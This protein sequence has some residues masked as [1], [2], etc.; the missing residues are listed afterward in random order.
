LTPQSESD[1]DVQDPYVGRYA[2]GYVT[3]NGLRLH[4]TRWGD[5]DKPCVMLVHGLNSMLHAW[6][7]I[8]DALYHDF[9]VVSVDLRGHGDSEWAREGYAVQHLIAD[10]HELAGEL[11]LP[12]FDFVGHSLGCR[13]GIAYAGTYPDALRHLVLSD[14]GPEVSRDT[15]IQV[16]TRIARS[17]DVKGFRNEAEALAFFQDV[18]PEWRPE[19]HQLY[20][21]HQL[22]LNWAGKLV[23]KAD[24][25]VFWLTGSAGLREVPFLWENAARI[26]C[27]TLIMRGKRS[28][29]LSAETAAKMLTVI[30]RAQLVEF[31]TGHHIPREAP[32]EFIRVLRDFLA[33]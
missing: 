29:F 19:F 4:Y 25:D 22:R 21:Q 2:D 17:A 7:P 1:V 31:D 8:A 16:R 3:A 15:G 24:P 33:S 27:P 9:F 26:T 12:P 11:Q 18:Y 14:A 13:I 32:E 5:R 10:I 28:Y 20:V 6:D 30:P 23:F